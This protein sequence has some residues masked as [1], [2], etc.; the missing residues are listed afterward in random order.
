MNHFSIRSAIYELVRPGRKFTKIGCIYDIAISLVVLL[1]LAPMMSKGSSAAEEIIDTVTAYIILFDYLLR[2]MTYD[3][4]RGAEGKIW[5]FLIYVFSP[6]SIITFVSLLPSFDLIGETWRV[7]RLLRVFTLFGYSR[8]FEKIG[9]VFTKQKDKL[10]I[11]LLIALIYIFASALIMF[12]FEPQTFDS[13]F[14]AVYWS[15]TALTTVG[16]GDIYPVTDVGRLISMISSLF[17]IAIIALPAG[18]MTSGFMEELKDPEEKRYGNLKGIREV[19]TPMQKQYLPKYLMVMGLCILCNIVLVRICEAL[20]APFWLDTFGT[21]M[22]SVLLEP[23][24]GI[25]VGFFT[26]CSETF[27][28]EKWAVLY[29]MTSAVAALIPGLMIR[30]KNKFRL[31]RFLPAMVITTLATAAVATVQTMLINSG[32]VGNIWEFKIYVSLRLIG[33]NEIQA[34]FISGLIIKIFDMA[35]TFFVLWLLCRNQKIQSIAYSENKRETES[36]EN[37]RKAE[38]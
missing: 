10:W 23:C 38:T 4:R 21:V 34:V 25:I 12:S 15:T 14:K 19:M 30:G 32:I 26:N 2:W 24:A 37:D 1:S 8:H 29:F 11:V 6:L 35:V 31:N 36:P 22:A 13:F 7:L 3:K 28:A 33:I 27:G 16:Y 9:N 20:K 18:I 17:G 5:P